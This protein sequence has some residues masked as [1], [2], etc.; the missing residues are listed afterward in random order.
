MDRHT[1]EDARRTEAL[2]TFFLGDQMT[3]EKAREWAQSIMLVFPELEVDGEPILTNPIVR[4]FFARLYRAVPFFL[5][6]VEQLDGSGM[7]AFLCAHARDDQIITDARGNFRIEMDDALDRVVVARL[8][9]AATYAFH[10]GCRW[11]N[12]LNGTRVS[13]EQRAAAR[14][15]VEQR[16]S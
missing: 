16:I 15:L 7:L 13:E 6:F 10:V 12:I 5:F 8:A 2:A 4:E 11:E 14:E 1:A 9:D 3:R